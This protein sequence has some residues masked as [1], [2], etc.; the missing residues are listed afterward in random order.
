MVYRTTGGLQ[1]YRW[2]AGLQ[3]DYRTTGGLQLVYRTTGGL[4]DYS[5]STG[6]QVDCR[7]TGG[8]QDLPFLL[9]T[10]EVNLARL[11]AAVVPH[12]KHLFVRVV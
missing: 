3:V 5:W 4:Q 10:C 12:V 6:L 9:Q 11:Q 8:L 1:D 2:T 7:T